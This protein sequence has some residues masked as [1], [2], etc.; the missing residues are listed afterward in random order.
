MGDEFDGV[1]CC[2]ETAEEAVD[3]DPVLPLP[4][5]VR[6]YVLTVSAV[7]MAL[8]RADTPRRADP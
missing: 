6:I 1:R 3:S 2:W 8:R 5:A 4:H 7:K